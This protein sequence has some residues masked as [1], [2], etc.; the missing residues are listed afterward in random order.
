MFFVHIIL[1][2][3]LGKVLGNYWYLL[4]GSLIVDIDHLVLL[5]KNKH[6]N[7]RE[8]IDVLKH[9]EK[10]GEHLR[11]PYMHSFFGL[12]ATSF[13]VGLFFSLTGA[14]YY[15]IGYLIHLMIDLFDKDVMHLLFPA[16]IRFNGVL[17]VPSHVEFAL[18]LFFLAFMV[19]LFV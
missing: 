18:T 12:I 5:I 15:A 11:S 17:P 2:L 9:E 8:C 16:K 6:Y 3:I 4:A 13:I 14:V 1:P 10:Y 19:V 7:L